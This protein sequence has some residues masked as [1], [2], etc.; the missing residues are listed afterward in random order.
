MFPDEYSARKWF[1]SIIWEDG[2]AVC[3]RCGGT[4]TYEVAGGKPLPYRCRDCRKHFSFRHGTLLEDSHVP[5]R[6]WAIAIYLLATSLKGVSSMKLHRDL[7]ITQKTAWHMLHK[8]RLA[9]SGSSGISMSGTVEVDETYVGGLER[10]KHE[11]DKL[12]VGRGS[13]G[14]T[15]VVGI[16][17]RG[18]KQVSAQVIDDT[19]RTT[20]H[21][22]IEDHTEACTSVMTDDFISYRQLDGYKHQFVRH[23]AGEYVADDVHVNGIESFWSMLKRAHKGTYHKMSRK[24]LDRYVS[25]FVGRHNIRELDTA[26]QMAS[27]VAGFVGRRLVNKDLVLMDGYIDREDELKKQVPLETPRRKG[28]D[29]VHTRA[30]RNRHGTSTLFSRG[31]PMGSDMY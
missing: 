18:S 17:E 16:K 3:H 13:V 8:I 23:P 9:I 30:Q 7:N 20:L 24:H 28:S 14:K 6:K 31:Q 22:F 1:E 27:I 25:E 2:G 26:A 4:N 19:R 15:A 29:D 10:N 12:K 21:G 11:S 5:L